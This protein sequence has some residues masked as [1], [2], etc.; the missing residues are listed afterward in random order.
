MLIDECRRVV[1]VTAANWAAHKIGYDRDKFNV[2]SY[3]EQKNLAAFDERI[4]KQMA[5]HQGQFDEAVLMLAREIARDRSS[6]TE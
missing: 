5:Y 4:E 6:P 3:E 1:V 2:P